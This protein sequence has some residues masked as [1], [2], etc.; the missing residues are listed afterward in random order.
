MGDNEFHVTRDLQG[1]TGA[2][3]KT[4]KHCLQGFNGLTHESVSEETYTQPQKTNSLSKLC[5][6]SDSLV[7]IQ[8]QACQSNMSPF[9]QDRATFIHPL[10]NTHCTTLGAEL[11][12]SP[13]SSQPHSGFCGVSLHQWC[14]VHAKE[15]ALAV[16]GEISSSYAFYSGFLFP[17][18]E[19]PRY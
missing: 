16:Q 2:F 3:Q 11:S 14:T 9:L 7:S 10:I 5:E 12:S 4:F 18:E 1:K 6:P 8:K 15:V 13:T 19:H 17:K